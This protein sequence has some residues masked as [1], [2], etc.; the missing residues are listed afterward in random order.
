VSPRSDAHRTNERHRVNGSGD[1]FD[2]A[3]CDDRNRFQ[4]HDAKTDPTSA[5]AAEQAEGKAE[6]DNVGGRGRECVQ[7]TCGRLTAVADAIVAFVERA[8]AMQI[9]V[10]GFGTMRGLDKFSSM[11]RHTLR[12][13]RLWRRGSKWAVSNRTHPNQCDDSQIV[14]AD[15]PATVRSRNAIGRRKSGKIADVRDPRRQRTLL[16]E[17]ADDGHP[18]GHCERTRT[19]RDDWGHLV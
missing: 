19:R 6:R 8:R 14:I 3:A 5:A 7:R 4:F 12:R 13:C 2:A 10:V 11:V 1:D 9:A 15:R 16:Q 18:E 17:A